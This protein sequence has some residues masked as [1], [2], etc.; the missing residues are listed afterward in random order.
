MDIFHA[1]PAPWA[2]MLQHSDRFWGRFCAIVR[3]E[4]TYDG[5]VHSFGPLFLALEPLARGARALTARR[6]GGGSAESAR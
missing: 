5:L 1:W 2:W 6:L 3:G 4:Q